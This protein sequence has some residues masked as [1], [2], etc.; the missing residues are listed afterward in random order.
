MSKYND[1]FVKLLVKEKEDLSLT[2]IAAKY[3]LTRSQAVYIIYKLGKIK[4]SK[5]MD[6]LY[7]KSRIYRELQEASD[8]LQKQ[9]SLISRLIKLI[10]G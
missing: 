9:N 6:L 10:T 4:E 1:E 3:K 5:L 7:P 8:D 2:Q